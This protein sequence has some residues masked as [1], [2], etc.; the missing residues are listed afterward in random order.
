MKG[1]FSELSISNL[2]NLIG[3]AILLPR[4]RVWL[5]L[6]AAVSVGSWNM[7]DPKDIQSIY[8][9]TNTVVYHFQKW[10]SLHTNHIHDLLKY[11]VISISTS[12]L[13]TL[14]RCCLLF[15]QFIPNS[16]KPFFMKMLYLSSGHLVIAFSFSSVLSTAC[17]VSD[18]HLVFQQQQQLDSQRYLA[19]QI[20]TH[21]WR[22]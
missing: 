22:P 7:L 20:I 10:P 5:V 6:T 18:G 9:A 3:K 19:T 15:C 2:A 11:T 16:G 14:Y 4:A 17:L 1:L 8:I 21:G 13:G 12:I